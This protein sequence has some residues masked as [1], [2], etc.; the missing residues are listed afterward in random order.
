[1]QYP[2]ITNLLAECKRRKPSSI[3]SK[4]NIIRAY[5]FFTGGKVSYYAGLL[6]VFLVVGEAI[7]TESGLAL[8]HKLIIMSG[9]LQGIFYLV[10]I[11]ESKIGCGILHRIARS[12]LRILNRCKSILV[13]SVNSDYPILTRLDER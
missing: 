8:F 4:N 11:L 13:C 7:R 9:A 2:P 12:L 6:L 1:M 5:Y 3:A 10:C